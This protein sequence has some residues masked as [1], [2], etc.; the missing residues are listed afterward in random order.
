MRDKFHCLVELTDAPGNDSEKVQR[1]RLLWV[2]RQNLPVIFC[3]L[4]K[5]PRLMM[6]KSFGNVAGR[7]VV[8]HSR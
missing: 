2:Y 7:G 6:A 1:I 4:F 3:R 5:A 8:V